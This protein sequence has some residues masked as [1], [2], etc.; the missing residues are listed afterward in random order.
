MSAEAKFIW[1]M[2]NRCQKSWGRSPNNFAIQRFNDLTIQQIKKIPIHRLVDSPISRER[3]E[4]INDYTITRD[5]LLKVKG[6][7]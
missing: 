3:S 5:N 6:N 4:Q 1:I 7:W 2:P